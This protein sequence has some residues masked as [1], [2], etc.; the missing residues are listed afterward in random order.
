MLEHGG[1]RH[2]RSTLPLIGAYQAANALV[3]AGLAIATGERA[4]AACSMRWRGC[5]RCAGGSSARSSP[6]AGAPVYVD[7]AH[8]PD[9]LEAAIA[10][11]R[12]HVG[13][14]GRLIAVFGAG[15]DRDPGQ[16]RADGRGGGR[17]RPTS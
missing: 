11:L 10:A 14:G 7:Y 17:A 1:V 13:E 4:G 8:T 5:S 2:T 16:A 15:G 12:P 6:P 3:A 9:A